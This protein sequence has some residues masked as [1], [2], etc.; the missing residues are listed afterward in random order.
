MYQSW[1]R[2]CSDLGTTSKEFGISNGLKNLLPL[3]E[4]QQF[5]P[6]WMYFGSFLA[7]AFPICA[8][9]ETEK[10]PS[11]FKTSSKFLKVIGGQ[12]FF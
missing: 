2:E 1:F 4:P 9:K 12:G 5:I 7:N 6:R 10:P 3:S 11:F 8:Q